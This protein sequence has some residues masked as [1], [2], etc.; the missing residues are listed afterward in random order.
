MARALHDLALES[1]RVC[2]SLPFASLVFSPQSSL[3]VVLLRL[4]PG[5]LD[6]F[7]PAATNAYARLFAAVVEQLLPGHSAREVLERYTRVRSVRRYI[8]SPKRVC[9]LSR[10]T[11]GADVAVTSVVL[12]AVK[13]CFPE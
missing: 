10:V 8:G 7:D 11:L 9:V 4:A 1:L 13:E 5:P 6:L 2:T 3:D 12:A